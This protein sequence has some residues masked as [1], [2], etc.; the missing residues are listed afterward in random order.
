MLHILERGSFHFW[1][2]FCFCDLNFIK[3]WPIIGLYTY[4]IMNRYDVFNEFVLNLERERLHL[5][6]S[7]VK[8]AAALDLSLSAY[9]RLIS[10]EN[11][12]IDFFLAYKL[13][14]LTGKLF[15]EFCGV[16]SPR[17]DLIA[18][19]RRLS[20]PQVNFINDMVDFELKYTDTYSP[21]TLSVIIP[22]GNIEDG[23]IYN[24][25]ALEMLEV[26]DLCSRFGV[27]ISHGLRITS[28]HLNPVFHNGDILLISKRPPRDGD[29]GIFICSDTHRAYIR[30][31]RS[32]SPCMLIP[33]NGYGEIIYIDATDPIQASKWLR[34]GVVVSKLRR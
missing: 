33:I 8:W 34:F 15:F 21:D 1:T 10:G 20:L 25:C 32:G 6:L 14:K 18:K 12:K 27:A 16:S 7:Q 31:L 17:L 3:Y 9:K 22:V 30:V 19:V 13:Y 23:M 11:K 5:G 28:N 2:F 4:C 26:P 29:I 24:S